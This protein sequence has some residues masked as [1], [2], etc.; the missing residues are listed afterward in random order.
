MRSGGVLGLNFA[1]A[2]LQNM[3][4]DVDC[5]LDFSNLRLCFSIL[6]DWPLYVSILAE[7]RVF[8]RTLVQ[9]LS[10]AMAFDVCTLGKQQR[11]VVKVSFR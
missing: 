1:E 6:G 8:L 2:S 5:F 3:A 4:F 11:Y 10:G 9:Y 7:L